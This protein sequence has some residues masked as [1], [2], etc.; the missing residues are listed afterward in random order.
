M[1]PKKI[2]IRSSTTTGKLTRNDITVTT[3]TEYNGNPISNISN[4]SILRVL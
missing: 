1:T 3:N 4:D 2:Y